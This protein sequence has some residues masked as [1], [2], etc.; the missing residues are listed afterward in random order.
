MIR[1]II[2]LLWNNKRHYAGIFTEQMLV[3]VILVL[4]MVSLLKAFRNYRTPGI[5]DTENV[6]CLGYMQRLDCNISPQQ[7]QDA[8]QNLN[9]LIQK[10][11]TLPYVEAIS[12]SNNFTPYLRSKEYYAKDSISVGTKKILVK[13]KLAEAD[14][15]KVFR[16]VPE[17]G[18]WISNERMEDDKL[19]AVITRQ[20]ADMNIWGDPIGKIFSISN[21]ECRIVGIIPGIKENAFQQSDPAVIIPILDFY[22]TF[23]REF[24]ARIKPGYEETFFND[25]TREF[26][27]LIPADVMEPILS[28]LTRWKRDAMSSTTTMLLFQAI[29]TFFL[30][31][32]AFIGIFSLFMLHS[33]KRTLEYSLKLAIG[34]TRRQLMTGV[35]LE[36]III[37][38]F[39]ALPGLL[40]T[41]F[42]Y[43]INGLYVSAVVCTLLLMLLFAVLSAWYPAYRLTK[44]NPAEALHNE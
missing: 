43:T 40:L 33:K 22:K 31:L 24:C 4:C 17:Q 15:Q 26:R 41:F 20:F 29:P 25:Y 27:R 23:Y 10:L 34:S 36:G 7:M 11:K 30:V 18:T 8:T 19:P 28:D 3:F 12:E 16:I 32:F 44:I 35:I 42:I 21:M 38:L 5:L 1:H 39:A 2:K 6:I 13:V 14:A 9:S 37:C